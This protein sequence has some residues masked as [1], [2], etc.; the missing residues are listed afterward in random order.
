MSAFVAAARVLANDANLSV[1][2]LWRPLGRGDGT[3]LRVTKSTPDDLKPVFGQNIRVGTLTLSVL[4]ADVALP[5]QSD[6][7]QFEG[8]T[9]GVFDGP[10]FAVLDA[11]LDA[12]GVSWTVQC[13][14]G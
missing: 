9:E 2:A 8:A 11:S 12:E 10:S 4:L 5:R 14:N 6:T 1:A 3:P 13:R 7:F